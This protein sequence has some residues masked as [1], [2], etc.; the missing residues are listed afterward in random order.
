MKKILLFVLASV[1][2]SCGSV[3]KPF[4]YS[5]YVDPFIGTDGIVHTFP[6]AAAPFGM[7]QL[8]PDGDTKGWNWCSG[9][10]SSDDNI[11]GFSHNHLS[12]TG[13]SDL[14]DILLTATVGQLQLTPGE[15][16]NPDGGYRSRIKHDSLNERASVGYYMVNL[17]D[18]G[19]RAELT[20][21]QRVGVH[22]YTFP[23]S[24]S[25]YV[26]IDP[27]NKIFGQ[28]FET[29][30]QVVNDSTI[31]GMCHSTGWGGDRK[32]YFVTQFSRPFDASAATDKA[33]ARFKTTQDEVV[34]VRVALSHVGQQGA[35]DNLNSEK[36]NFE[37]V[38]ARTQKSWETELGKF[39]FEGVD[40]QQ[41]RILYTGL[42]HVM[43]Q[44]NLNQDV[45][46]QYV[47]NGKVEYS[48]GFVNYSTFSFWDTFRAAQPLL[49][50]VNEQ[51]T[52]DVVNTLSARYAT[53]GHLP[54]WEL[55][56]YDNTCMIGYPAVAVMG[57]AIMK[58]V[59]GIDTQKAYTA[60]RDAAFRPYT[61][62][63]DGESGLRE[64]IQFGYVPAGI[65]ASVSK[66][67]EYSYYDW[68][69]ARVAE[70]LGKTEDAALF[71]KRSMNFLNHWNPKQKLMWPKDS[72]GNWVA[73]NL[74]DWSSLQQNYVSGNVWAYSYFYPHAVDTMITVMGGADAFE[75]S[76]DDVL[77]TPLDM[78]GAQHLDLT[79]FIGHYG[80]GDEPG[81][82]F[83]YLYNKVGAMDK[84]AERVRE[85]CSEYYSDKRD[86]MPN[87]D[88]CGQMSA[89]YIMSAMGFYPLSPGDNRYYLGSPMMR[90]AKILTTSGKEFSMVAH[91]LSPK[92]IYIDKVVLNGKPLTRGYITHQ[93]IVGGARLEF[94]MT[95]KK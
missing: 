63:S 83:L 32:V 77:N 90:S 79:G 94:Y 31:I 55:L 44:P 2:L 54:L 80:H 46:G 86:G 58:D 53:G 61:S 71:D 74:R 70:K 66:T 57:D 89:W 13:W 37:N 36:G 11:M 10:H 35:W 47:A 93:E 30:T 67:L 39:Q 8:S 84:I 51:I 24:D 1:A 4:N 91:D 12:G 14:G 17:L 81:H 65:P 59:A 72:L 19:V 28:V 88:D 5:Q 95:D 34:E 41:M 60:M 52:R 40:E 3:V 16:S 49:T 18:Y 15:K 25:S 75:K 87:N 29:S 76:M 73:Q 56:G 6:G 85:V 92:N 22:R 20:A 38:L 26:I 69:V 7:I 33:W 21:G 45:G 64:Y 27:T 48:D 23:Q 78:E 62:S 42:Y 43:L 9:Y 82:Q 68:V 50:I